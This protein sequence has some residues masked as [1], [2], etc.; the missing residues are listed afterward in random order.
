M[1]YR[2]EHQLFEANKNKTIMILWVE[3]SIIT[4]P[5]KILYYIYTTFALLKNRKLKKENLSNPEIK[6]AIQ[7]GAGLQE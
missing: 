1:M 6:E 5:I 4:V 3:I 2:S 7:D